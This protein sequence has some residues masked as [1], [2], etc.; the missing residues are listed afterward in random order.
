M[1]E[2]VRLEHVQKVYRM[3]RVAVRALND[4]SF[5]I[6]E[7]EHVA[8]MGHSGSGKS[9]LLN[10]LGCLDRPT[11]G[12]YRFAGRDVSRM[13]DAGLSAIRGQHIG[14]VFQSFNL[15]AELTVLA[16]IEVPLFYQGVPRRQRHRR[17][18][19]LAEMVGLADR[20]RH[21][22]AELSGGERQRVAI[23]RAMANDPLLLL[24]D[25]PT[26]NLDSHTT[27]EI[28]QIFDELWRRGR[29]IITVTHERDVAAHA[30]RVIVL[31]DGQVESDTPAD[32]WV[33]GKT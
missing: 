28:L 26:G 22:P 18:M 6:E 14:F 13:T 8:V 11:R 30:G 3:G 31:R 4:V 7:G 32:H 25:E 23:A 15:I 1:N 12:R 21:R 24:A 19:E 9:T 17:S 2:L 20:V 10:L 29:T 16:N 33:A 27:D 5:A